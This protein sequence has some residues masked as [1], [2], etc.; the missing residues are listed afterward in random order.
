MLINVCGQET[1]EQRNH[2]LYENHFSSL[3]NGSLNSSVDFK[4][5]LCNE[6]FVI[7]LL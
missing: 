3:E 7:G 1:G 2:C 4:S 6:V 5:I